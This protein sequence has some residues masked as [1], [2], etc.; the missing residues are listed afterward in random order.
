[1]PKREVRLNRPRDLNPDRNNN[2]KKVI[3]QDGN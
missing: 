1:M 2:K 3:P